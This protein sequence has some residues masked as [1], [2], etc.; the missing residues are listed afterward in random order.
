MNGTMHIKAVPAYPFGMRIVR[1][2]T[3]VQV[4]VNGQETALS[5]GPPDWSGSVQND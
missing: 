5:V 1:T 2:P 4:V 3:A